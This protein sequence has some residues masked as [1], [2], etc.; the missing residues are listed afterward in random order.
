MRKTLLALG[1]LVS[2]SAHAQYRCQSNGKSVYS[3]LPCAADAKNVT[4]LEDKVDRQARYERLRQNGKDRAAVA[5]IEMQKQQDQYQQARLL[6]QLQAQD[7]SLARAKAHNCAQAK[8]SRSALN[9][10]EA[11]N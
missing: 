5:S 6:A 1:L 8:R 2:L 9:V 7:N 10:R 3:D 4:A 11:C